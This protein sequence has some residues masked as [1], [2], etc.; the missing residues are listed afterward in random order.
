MNAGKPW[1]SMASGD[2]PDR[3]MYV[4]GQE[5]ATTRGG[6][7]ICSDFSRLDAA[8]WADRFHELHRAEV[9]ADVP[10]RVAAG[11][12][13]GAFDEQGEDGDH[14]VRAD[15]VDGV[16]VDGAHDEAGLEGPPRLL[17]AHELLVAEGEVFGR[18]RVVVGVPDEL[19]VEARGDGDLRAVDL[20]TAVRRCAR[21]PPVPSGRPQG[22]LPLAVGVFIAARQAVQLG[23][24]LGDHAPP[25]WALAP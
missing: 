24:E 6:F 20:Q 18:Q 9:V 7:S 13:G 15:A 25:V 23:L 12:F 4:G 22:A 17:D 5:R 19:P 2:L 3:D 14:E 1:R 21:V 10:P 11:A 8:V 16:V